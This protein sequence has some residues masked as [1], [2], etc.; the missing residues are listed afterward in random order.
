V[1]EEE[2]RE[3]AEKI[4]EKQVM[5]MC[6][7]KWEQL[8]SLYPHIS[9]FQDSRTFISLTPG[10]F[11]LLPEKYFSVAHNSFL[12][13]GY[14]NYKHLILKRLEYRSE[15]KYYLGVPGN[16]YDKEKQVAVMFGFESFESL[17]E[18]AETGEYGYYLMRVE[19]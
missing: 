8:W 15:V 16:F 3:V 4:T 12:L 18:T 9:P 10:D 17:Q 13:H 2:I 11:V 14:Y 6:S 5:K 7:N 19:L 1:R